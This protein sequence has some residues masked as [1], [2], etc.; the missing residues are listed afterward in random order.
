MEAPLLFIGII[1]ALFTGLYFLFRK[2]YHLSNRI[3]SLFMLFLALPMLIDLFRFDVFSIP[4]PDRVAMLFTF[5]FT[6]GPFLYLYT[7]IEIDEKP[8]F[9][10]SY[11]LH[12]IPFVLFTVLAL[13]LPRP[14]TREGPGP[15][16]MR[17]PIEGPARENGFNPER[18]NPPYPGMLPEIR[19]RERQGQ[20]PLGEGRMRP[21][22]PVEGGIVPEPDPLHR[23]ITAANFLSIIAYSIL[24]PVM[25]R[26][27][28]K[29]ISEYYSF[30]SM[31]V[32]LKWLHWIVA[33]FCIAFTYIFLTEDIL[34]HLYR[35]PLLDPRFSHG[36]GLTFFI[37]AFS[38]FS[39]KQPVLFGAAESLDGSIV[40][41]KGRKYEKSGLKDDDAAGYLDALENYMREEKPYLNGDLSIVEVSERLG[42]PRHHITQVINGRLNKNFYS[43]VNDYRIR[44]ATEK[45]TREDFQE[46]SIIRIAYD[47]GFNSK[48]AFNTIFKKYT[49]LTPSEY[50]KR[51]AGKV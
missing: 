29:K 5:P 8:V 2:P 33:C 41:L 36:I 51:H 50:R 49:G 4:L 39:I 47:S 3:V 10:K 42:I 44:Y 7:K 24:I 31:S 23:A 30:Y 1:Q 12:F 9:R 28:K 45:M 13:L 40:E 26:G 18:L 34:F 19:P 35:H 43:Y 16:R 46:H 15:D 6:F 37:F 21:H 38:L 22:P 27:H 48:S 17:P 20:P 14:V 11:L 32:N 25:L